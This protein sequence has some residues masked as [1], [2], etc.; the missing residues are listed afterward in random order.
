[1]LGPT[2]AILLVMTILFFTPAR[3]AA[4]E[5]PGFPLVENRCRRFTEDVA[6]PICHQLNDLIPTA[7]ARAA[8]LTGFPIDA[9]DLR[10]ALVETPT[11]PSKSFTAMRIG[12][13][14][15][16][17]LEIR[18]EPIL[19]GDYDRGPNLG[20]SLTHEFVHLAIRQQMSPPA[21]A[22]LPEWFQEGVA[23]YLAD[24]GTHKLAVFLS[25]AC[26]APA[27]LIDACLDGSEELPYI[28]GCFFLTALAESSDHGDVLPWV[29]SVVAS[30]SVTDASLTHDVDI[31]QTWRRASELLQASIGDLL[32]DGTP[33]RCR[34]EESSAQ[35]RA[36]AGDALACWSRFSQQHREPLNQALAAYWQAKAH[37]ELRDFEEAARRFAD[38][39]DVTVGF[40]LL[41][42][43]QYYRLKS[44]YLARSY[45][46]ALDACE[47]FLL[48]YPES[49]H[50]KEA[51]EGYWRLTALQGR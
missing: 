5:T 32:G 31:P 51:L 30:G 35:G 19:R 23:T 28:C 13:R 2:R 25:A 47:Q 33:D 48:H 29:R 6:V 39:M 4:T 22:A 38:V 18:I 24:Q 21:Y 27:R 1:M 20:V 11:R 43:A 7:A 34:C 50:R 15:G 40:G 9:N 46:D 17:V 14:D 42:D 36:G 37:Y 41:D 44:L 8:A 12:R 16:H 10:I 45:D 26:D 3:S 49:G